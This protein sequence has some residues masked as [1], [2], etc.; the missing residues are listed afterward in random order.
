MIVSPENLPRPIPLTI[1]P[2][3]TGPPC[4]LGICAAFGV[5]RVDAY[6]GVD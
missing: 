6:C 2:R 3:Y 5:S 1:M 4:R